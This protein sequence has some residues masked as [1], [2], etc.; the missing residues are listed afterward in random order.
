MLQRLATKVLWPRRFF[1]W[2]NVGRFQKKRS[3]QKKPAYTPVFFQFAG[4]EVTLLAHPAL[5]S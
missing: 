3:K 5:D 2:Y 1:D 4:E